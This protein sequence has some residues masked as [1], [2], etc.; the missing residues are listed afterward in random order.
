MDSDTPELAHVLRLIDRV[1]REWITAGILGG[2]AAFVALLLGLCIVAV[3]AEM[4]FAPPPFLR[5]TFLVLLILAALIGGVLFVV[6][7][8]L[9][10]PQDEE[11]ALIIESCRPDLH[12]ELINAVRLSEDADGDQGTYVKAAIRESDRRASMIESNL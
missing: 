5:W 6:K 1:R 7:R 10:E 3:A 12:N 8:L 11:V 4:L 2:A 9:H